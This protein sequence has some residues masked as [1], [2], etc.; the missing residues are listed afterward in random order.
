VALAAAL[1][2]AIPGMPQI[3]AII[4]PI[5]FAALAWSVVELPE[6]PPAGSRRMFLLPALV[7]LPI[8]FGVEY[9]HQTGGFLSHLGVAL[10]VA[11]LLIIC[12]AVLNERY[13]ARPNLRR[14]CN[15]MIVAAS[16]QV[17]LGMAAFVIRMLEL[18]GGL[19]L[20]VART[21]HIT[22]AALVLAA[23]A[24]L[25]IQYRRGAA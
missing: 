14:V 9:R 8:V 25:A 22:G 16:A 11:G 10:P 3:H 18:Q 5:L 24:E 20:A 7:L 1:L 4:S 23:S 2:E 21:A 19:L 15:L 6:T 12:P 17:V 13:P